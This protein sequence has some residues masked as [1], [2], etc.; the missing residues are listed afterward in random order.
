[1]ASKLTELEADELQKQGQDLYRQKKYQ[2][3]L[4]RF[5]AVDIPRYFPMLI[6]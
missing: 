5:N 6:R 1:M 4:Q 3:A 2:A